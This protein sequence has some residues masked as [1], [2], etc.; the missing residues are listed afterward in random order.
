VGLVNRVVPLPKLMDSA[1]NLAERIVA[2]PP[3]ALQVTKEL[4]YRGMDIPLREGLRL[5]QVYTRVVRSTE[6]SEEARNAFR[7]KRP[8]EYKGR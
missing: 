6:D 8:P 5:A 2:N 3:I 4:V 1:I 7:D